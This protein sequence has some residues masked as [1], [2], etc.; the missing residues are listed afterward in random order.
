MLIYLLIKELREVADAKQSKDFIMNDF[1]VSIN[2][3]L[4]CRF[5]KESQ[6][7]A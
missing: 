7:F 2:K 1:Y 6:K 3:Y 4:N 5:K